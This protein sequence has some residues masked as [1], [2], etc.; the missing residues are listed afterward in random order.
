MIWIANDQS[1][2]VAYTYRRG[3]Y[4]PEAGRRFYPDKTTYNYGIRPM[5]VIKKDVKI[6]GGNG[7]TEEPYV[8]TDDTKAKSGTLLNKREIGEILDINGYEFI[9]TDTL[10][11]GTTKVISYSTLEDIDEEV[12]IQ[13]PGKIT[14]NPKNKNN[15]AYFIN[16]KASKYVDS[17][18]FVS[19]EVE[20]PIYKDRIIYGNE[21]KI[22]KYKLKLSPPNMYE[23]FSA[24]LNARDEYVENSYWL[25]NSSTS[26]KR[27]VGVVSRT[28]TILN[29]PIEENEEFGI[30]VVGYIKK[31]TVI[32]S[33]DGSFEDPYVVK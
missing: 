16:N 22:K 6:K 28:G 27:Y 24:Q 4:G 17:S 25:L 18:L 14:F 26:K 2:S 20:V 31:G 7:T 3:F 29:D 30:K 13:S 33:G 21:T 19:H 15:Y 9:I 23:M 11:D 8:L 12:H 1:S 10:K 5:I 32:T